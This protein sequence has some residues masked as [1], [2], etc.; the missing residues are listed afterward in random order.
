MQCKFTGAWLSDTFKQLQTVVDDH[1]KPKQAG[2]IV[3]VAPCKIH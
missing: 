2:I 3:Y 1:G